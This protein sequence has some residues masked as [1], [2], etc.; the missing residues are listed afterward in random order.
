[1]LTEGGAPAGATE[2][3]PEETEVKE[4]VPEE[5]TSRMSSPLKKEVKDGDNEEMVIEIP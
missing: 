5:Y 2:G 3:V 1:M 4:L